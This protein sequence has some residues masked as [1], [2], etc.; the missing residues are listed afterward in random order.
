MR[1][2]VLWASMVVVA[3]GCGNSSK[4][5]IVLGGLLSQSGAL[6]T[7]G[8]EEIQAAQMAIDEINAG[9]GVLGSNLV[10]YNS[11]DGSDSART[12]QAA[13][14]LLAARKPVAILG[15]LGSGSTIAASDVTI[16]AGVVLFS[17]ASTSPAITSLDD[18]DTVFR[19]CA[20]DALQGQLLAKRA[21]AKG[22]TSVAVIW[23]PGPYGKG[24]ADQFKTSFTAAGGTV[25]VS[26]MYV[27]NQQSYMSLL[28]SVYASTPAPEAVLLIAYSVDAAQIIKDYNSAFASQQT[29]WFFTDATEDTSFV[30][31]VGGSNFTFQH[32]GTGPATPSTAAYDSYAASFMS[33][34]AKKADPGTFSPNVYDATYL[35]ALAMQKG[36]MA[37]SATIKANLRGVANPPGTTVG[38]G[39]W[40]AALTA[41]Q[42]GG[43]VNYEGASGPVDLD[44]TAGEPAAPY[45]IWKVSSG[46][47][48]V[49][50]K[51][52]S[53]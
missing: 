37:T 15:A 27:E 12:A 11:D 52:V 14:E 34:F 39:Q 16:P 17:G 45:D 3:G 28:T 41:L 8:Q 43:D 9:G 32:E 50:E 13:T 42:A 18:N 48:T 10:L 19:S 23:I 51:S 7:I 47:I 6:S 46:A 29:F 40:A 24:L 20:S 49:V 44:A 1:K 36:G 26:Q 2:V 53:P 22:F 25:P 31:A 5:S 35:I 30:S 38:P 4:S 33:K 21:K